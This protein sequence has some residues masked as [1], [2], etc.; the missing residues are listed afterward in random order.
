MT[1]TAQNI[2]RPAVG[3]LEVSGV[4]VQG[5]RGWRLQDV[6]LSLV[7]G[8]VHAVMGPNGAGKSTLLSVLSGT[9]EPEAGEILFEHQPLQAWCP[10]ILARR[11]GILPQESSV[12]FPLT[13]WEVVALGRLPHATPLE[14]PDIVRRVMRRMDVHHLAAQ[15]YGDLSGGERQRVQMAR[16]LAQVARPVTDPSAP[17]LLLDEPSSALDLRHQFELFERMRDEALTGSAILVILHDLNLAARYADRLTL[18][19]DG[20]VA[21]QGSPGEVLDAATLER[22]WGVRARV[23]PVDAGAPLHVHLLGPADA[24]LG[25]GSR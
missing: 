16:V 23:T 1:A 21:A 24:G 8:E 7:P 11:R 2:K 22:V 13:V 3:V 14:D 17:V 15:R 12:S 19:H 25:A 10:R 20:H 4:S 5:H 6:S 18:L 9:L